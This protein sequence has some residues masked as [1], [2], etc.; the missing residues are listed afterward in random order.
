[1]YNDSG[2]QVVIL[3]IVIQ[4]LLFWV[5]LFFDGNLKLFFGENGYT[6]NY[7]QKRIRIIAS[8]LLWAYLLLFF[9][10]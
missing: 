2:F 1:M 10:C 9:G 7:T 6:Q 5:E 4:R 8:L 3:M